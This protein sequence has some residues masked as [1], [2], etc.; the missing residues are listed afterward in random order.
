MN[1]DYYV[2]VAD[3]MLPRPNLKGNVL[4]LSKSESLSELQ[5]LPVKCKD[6]DYYD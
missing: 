5:I 4:D 1:T 6:V 2:N 3:L